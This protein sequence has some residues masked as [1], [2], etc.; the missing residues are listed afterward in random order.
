MGCPY[1][2]QARDSNGTGTNENGTFRVPFLHLY[3]LLPR[4]LLT[5]PAPS[6]TANKDGQP[7]A[8]DEIVIPPSPWRY[9]QL[10]TMSPGDHAGGPLPAEQ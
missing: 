8:H 3:D 4:P 1:R 7:D 5:P 10:A 9:P 6:K 2:E